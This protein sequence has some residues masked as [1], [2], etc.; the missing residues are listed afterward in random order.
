MAGRGKTPIKIVMR[1]KLTFD[2]T[3]ETFCL[4]NEYIPGFNKDRLMFGIE[5]KR[6]TQQDFEDIA[7]N[8]R[9]G[10]NKAVVERVKLDRLRDNYNQ[11]FPT[12][13]KNLLTTPHC[14]FNTV[15]SCIYTLRNSILKFC[16][17]NRQKGSGVYTTST[18]TMHT[19]YLCNHTP[20]SCVLFP[21]S[22][23]SFVYEVINLLDNY[24]QL[25]TDIILISSKLIEEEKEIRN[26][27]E[28][29]KE[30][31]ARSRKEFEELAMNLKSVSLLSDVGITKEDLERRKKEG[32]SIKE[33]RRLLYHNITPLEYKIR[34]FKDFIMQGISTGLTEEESKIWTKEEDYDFVKRRVR[35]AIDGLSKKED[36]PSQRTRNAEGRTVK[37]I[38]IACFMKWC[39]VPKNKSKDFISYLTMR[40][41]DSP[42]QIPAYKSVVGAA[43]R[44]DNQIKT[45]FE[46]DFYSYS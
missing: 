10:M 21:D 44:L 46:P 35:P 8:L 43:K 5:L 26:N 2:K 11:T 22:Y 17:R 9:I 39:R 28:Y 37:A 30:I 29:L 25:A 34:I 20:Y 4:L 45:Q 14:V 41:A 12:K 15:K 23:P 6:F 1:T 42:F 24:I 27:D 13:D 16:P 32:K 18:Q 31:D 19:S 3:E 7:L 36:L 40:F 33:M 38:Y